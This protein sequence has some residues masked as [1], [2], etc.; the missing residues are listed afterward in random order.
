MTRSA[1]DPSVWQ[2]LFEGSPANALVLTPGDWVIVGVTDAYLA[3]TGTTREAL[4]GR[5]VFEAFPNLPGGST[6]QGVGALRASLERVVASAARDALPTQSYPVRI[7]E[8][9]EERSWSVVNVPILRADGTVVAIVHRAEDVTAT[10]QLRLSQ[11]RVR[12]T[13]DSAAVGIAILNLDRSVALA[14]RGL[15]ELLGYDE[16]ELAGRSMASITHV[17]DLAAT[18]QILREIVAGTS[19]L[20]RFQKRYHRKDGTVLWVRVSVA[21]LRDA[22]GRLRHLVKVMEDITAER[23]AEEKVRR[24]SSLL[25][26]AGRIGRIGGWAIDVAENVVEWSDEIFA[27]LEHPKDVAPSL[28]GSIDRYSP[29][30]RRRVQDAIAETIATGRPFD[31]E[32]E[33]E[34]YQGRWLAVR[35]VGEAVRDAHGR[36]TQ[37]I[38][39][40]QDITEVK[41]A[42]RAVRDAG[43]HLVATLEQLPTALYTIDRDWRF[44]YLNR[45]AERLLERAATDLLGRVL[46][47]EFP[48][49]RESPLHPAYR[50]TMERRETRHIEV[51]YPPLQHWFDVTAHPSPDGGIVVYFRSIDDRKA[52]EAARRADAERL[53]EQAMLLDE[54]SDAI[55]VRDLAGVIR[56]WNRGAERLYGWRAEEVIGKEVQPLAY[57]ESAPY[58]AAM[59]IVLAA[60]EWAGELEQVCRNGELVTVFSRWTLRRDESGRPSSVLVLD[61]DVTERRR[62]ER[63]FLRSQRLESIGTLAGGI[64]HDLNNALAPILMSIELLRLEDDPR[65]RDAILGTIE[66][67][68]RRGAEMVRQVLTFARGAEGQRVPVDVRQL[69]HDCAKMA[70][71]T[72]LKG[73][74]VH[75]ELPERLPRVLGDATQLHQ[76]LINLCVNAR[77]AMERGPGILRLSA[78]VITVDAQYAALVP[79]A[80]PGRYVRVEVED[81]GH[82]MTPDVLDKIFEPFFTTK[83]LGKGTGLG[84]P[85][86]KAI[87]EGHGGFLRIY[88]EPGRGTR[89][90]VHIPVTDL[91]VV[92]SGEHAVTQAL[93]RGRGELVLVVDDEPA[94]REVTRQ[95]LEAFGYRVVTA[96]DGAEG[97]ATYAAHRHEIAVVLT[98]IMMPVMDGNALVA[99]LQR[100]D[101]AVRIIAAS[102]LQGQGRGTRGDLPGVAH[103]LAKPYGAEEL[104]WALARLL[105]RDGM[106]G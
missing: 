98:D 4:L 45:Q 22:D 80:E 13:F 23:E 49:A 102:G 96:S 10:E 14:N 103:F 95:T 31:L 17:D 7:G 1:L 43:S 105:G 104:L 75:T 33:L 83:S 64:A 18:E 39:A 44:T 29:D 73:I 94:V 99:V 88:S 36:V 19:S 59:Q 32:L 60:G 86:S 46:W 72:F 11:A 82:G 76:V 77:D 71:E 100:L 91:D 20:G 56:F 101:P 81:T 74:T 69:V 79:E 53:A 21:P 89:V 84:L 54:T 6:P 97:V 26:M 27:I 8:R 41:A 35:A 3:A 65:E 61:S 2:Q 12:A 37:V 87:V 90:Q 62:L 40:L 51:W 38:G 106:A 42:E 15:C 58:E 25:R 34:S 92:T 5:A 67:S 50:E 63:Q 28:D 24:S 30:S 55:L 78:N 52:A 70:D 85:T 68:A 16:I 48:E 57:R 47:D 93:P 66:A 9:F